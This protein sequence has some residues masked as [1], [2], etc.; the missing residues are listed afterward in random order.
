MNGVLKP[1]KDFAPCRIVGQMWM[2]MLHLFCERREKANRSTERFTTFA[3]E[4]LLEEETETCR[5][6]PLAIRTGR[7]RVVRIPNGGPS[8]RAP[9]VEFEY[10][11]FQEPRSGHNRSKCPLTAILREPELRQ[12][13]TPDV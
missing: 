8:N 7:A 5:A 11:V 4:R 13:M 12:D 3:K 9:I 6:P 1:I 2:Y 10:L